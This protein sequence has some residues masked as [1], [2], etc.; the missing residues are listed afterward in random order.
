VTRVVEFDPRLAFTRAV[1]DTRQIVR[2][3]FIDPQRRNGREAG[4]LLIGRARRA[5]HNRRSDD[6][7]GM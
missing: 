4:R 1:Q 6:L 5:T 7:A 2:F 3:D